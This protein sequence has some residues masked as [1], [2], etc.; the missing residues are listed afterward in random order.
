MVGFALAQN[1]P[2]A[3]EPLQ[4]IV[5]YGV[6]QPKRATSHHGAMEPIGFPVGQPLNITL[7]FLRKRAGDTV[8]I[9]PVDGG[10]TNLE[11]P[12]QISAEGEIQ[13]TFQPGSS[14]GLYRLTVQ[15]PQQYDLS[16]YAVNP[17]AATSRR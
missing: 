8:I 1:A 12:V 7:Q 13:F 9:T 14:P 5:D 16:L 2:P 10:Q 6:G 11:G 3:A 4:M 17:S 15:G